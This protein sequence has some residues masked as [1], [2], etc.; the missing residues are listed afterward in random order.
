M[1]PEDKFPFHVGFILN[2]KKKTTLE[3]LVVGQGPN[4]IMSQN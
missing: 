4:G 3:Y 1:L 2:E